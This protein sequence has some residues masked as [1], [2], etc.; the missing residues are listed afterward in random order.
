MADTI[1]LKIETDGSESIKTLGK[2]NEEL[3]QMKNEIQ[4]VAV[5]SKE[6]KKLSN[7]I[8][9]TESEV[10][11]LEKSFEG[12]DTEALTGEFGKLAGGISAGMTGI[13]VFG[14]EANE[15]MEAMVETVAK[16][17]AVAEGFRGATEAA[18]AAQRVYNQ[19]LKANP[20]GLIVT[21][22][23]GFITLLVTLISKGDKIIEMLDGWAEKFEF[24]QG[25]INIVKAGI[26][27][28]M[29][30]W[31]NVQRWILGDEAVDKKLAEKAEKIRLT[32]KKA[33]D[34]WEI[35]R[36]EAIKANEDKIYEVKRKSM[37]DRLKLM[38]LE[39]K[40]NTDD[41]KQL[42]IDLLALDTD[43]NLKKEEQEKDR[44]EK[45]AQAAQERK[46]NREKEL[47]DKK[48]KL[49]EEQNQILEQLD[50]EQDIAIRKMQ[51]EGKTEDEI[52]Q[53]RQE[54][55][56]AR[57]EKLK[58]FYG[59]ES[60][61]YIEHK[62]AM[63]EI[64][65]EYY[66]KQKEKELERE[67][68]EKEKQEEQREKE[69]ESIMDT[70][71][72]LLQMDEEFFEEKQKLL[73]NALKNNKISLEQ[74][75]KSKLELDD[76]QKE[77]EMNKVAAYAQAAGMAADIFGEETAAHKLLASAQAI[78]NTYLAASDAIATYSYPLGGIFA[79][80]AIAQGLQ[81]VAK[82]N[83]VTFAQGGILDG[84]SHAQGGIQTP[85]GELEGGEGIINKRSMSVPSLRNLASAANVAG[86]GRDFST[87]DGSIKLSEESLSMLA[88]AINNK[89]VYVVESD[90]TETQ[91]TI[92]VI[93]NEAIL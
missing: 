36:L 24:L 27:G 88:S 82:I 12:L 64:E 62:I 73:D 52:F 13:A 50:F 6:F 28:L 22:V 53:K 16:G 58:E 59:E 25:P 20:I 11:N 87:G 5:G 80:L 85:Y 90:I 74:Y 71:L 49:E 19:V 92:S 68:K 2:L 65:K 37:L 18:T 54:Q 45:E 21:A 63:A 34:D 39:G 61:D 43:Y 42:Q 75:T 15:S 57:L 33:N 23:A 3:E 38:E 9:S 89:K 7:T 84:P 66:D 8:R 72:N 67:E 14:G 79:A 41:Y 93:E 30:A 76:L 48:S 83:S 4:D 60:N 26:Q 47:E 10:K 69:L 35:K 44:K 51:L 31:E 32:E 86:G 81:Q 1:K 56:S 29:D 91:N 17:M 40:Q 77:S 55:M 70:N 78:I 46:D